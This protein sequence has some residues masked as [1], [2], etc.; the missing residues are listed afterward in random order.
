MS[1]ETPS[2]KQVLVKHSKVNA[3]CIQRD[4]KKS[5]MFSFLPTLQI[6]S[7]IQKSAV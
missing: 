2:K 1:R 5:D 4:N 7:G 3:K 6:L